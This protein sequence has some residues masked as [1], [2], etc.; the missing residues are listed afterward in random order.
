MLQR[1]A[2]RG[3]QIC[4]ASD[5]TILPPRLLIVKHFPGRLRALPCWLLAQEIA[6]AFSRLRLRE[7]HSVPSPPAY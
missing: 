4:L 3:S 6:L 7:E 1:F 2:E 5:R